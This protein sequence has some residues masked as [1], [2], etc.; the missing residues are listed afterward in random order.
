M[1]LFCRM[2]LPYTRYYMILELNDLEDLMVQ[3]KEYKI[4]DI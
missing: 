4:L 1:A 3:E 2:L